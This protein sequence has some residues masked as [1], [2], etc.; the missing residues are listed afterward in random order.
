[1]KIGLLVLSL[2]LSFSL[3]VALLIGFYAWSKNIPIFLK[4]FR[5]IRL[6]YAILYIKILKLFG[7]IKWIRS[8]YLKLKLNDE[9]T[10]LESLQESDLVQP[11]STE[12]KS[13]RPK[14]SKEKYSKR[15]RKG[16]FTK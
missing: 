12:Q 10:L 5:W 4:V 15:D 16:R 11:T 14:S 8:F 6:G 9:T 13:G 7:K 3:V 1:M 2:V